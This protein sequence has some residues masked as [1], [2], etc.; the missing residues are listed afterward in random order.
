MDNRLKVLIALLVFLVM[1]VLLAYTVAK[2]FVEGKGEILLIIF[3][4][5]IAL[6]VISSI[7]RFVKYNNRDKEE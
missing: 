1:P 3:I 4:V 5:L 7:Y 6:S 2:L